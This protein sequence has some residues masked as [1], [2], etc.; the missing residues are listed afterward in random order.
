MQDCDGPEILHRAVL[1]PVAVQ[2]VTCSVNLLVAGQRRLG[3][4]NTASL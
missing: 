3:T 4:S 1:A 2:S